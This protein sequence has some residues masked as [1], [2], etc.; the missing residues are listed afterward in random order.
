MTAFW[1]RYIHVA[2]FIGFGI[3]VTDVGAQQAS[4]G[5][6]P[7]PAAAS[8]GPPANAKPATSKP[9]AKAA[10]ADP[11]IAQGE[12][13]A[14]ISALGQG[15]LDAAVASLTKALSAGSLPSSQT[16]RVLYYRGV[17]HRRQNK[18][19]LAI[20]DLTNALWIKSGLTEQQ[21]ADALQQRSGAYREAGLPDQADPASARQAM[22]AKAGSSTAPFAAVAPPAPAGSSTTL[23]SAGG[24]FS[25]LFGGGAAS[26]APAEPAAR[27]ATAAAATAPPRTTASIPAGASV[28]PSAA[29]AASATETARPAT[30]A[31]PIYS[32]V[33][34]SLPT[35]FQDMGASVRHVEV[36]TSARAGQSEAAAQGR[37]SNSWED[38][39]K[40]KQAARPAAPAGTR[41][42]AA[43]TMAAAAPVA[44]A[45][46]VAAGQQVGTASPRGGVIVQVAAVRSVQEAQGVSEKLRAQ[47][48]RELAGRAP[49]VDQVTAGDFGTFY[50][51][52][53]GPFAS[54][55]E[56]EGLC[57][58]LKSGG[59]DCRVVGR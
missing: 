57:A 47:F 17:A 40:V 18:P 45:P 27:E 16:A 41:S 14:G 49:V 19:A 21:R 44:T 6:Q 53:V 43:P 9:A 52:Q 42:A 15:R 10:K 56:T 48:A 22:K 11:A 29:P 2:A 39:T 54:A 8:K 46:V 7:A 26:T 25:S 36:S 31:V 38:V 12:A 37:V 51:V 59:L 24:F 28:V 20:S 58:K 13:E 30:R 1:R 35:G 32:S 23:S 50:R 5:A 55:R 3:S 34:R 4:T 33:D